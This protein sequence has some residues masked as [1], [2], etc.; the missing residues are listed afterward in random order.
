MAITAEQLNILITATNTASKQFAA[1]RRDANTMVR[2]L[3]ATGRT[4]SR[5]LTL[6]LLAIG[7]AATKMAV[8]FDEEMTKIITLVGVAEVQVDRWRES[9]LALGP[10][11]GVGPTELARALF[12]VTS[13]GERGAEA[14]KIVEFAAMAAAIGLGDTA[15]TARAVTAAMQAY[16]EE[17]L[18]AARATDILV[19]TVRAGNLVAADLAGSLGRVLATASS[20]SVSFQEVG[21]FIATFT[22]LGVSAEE[23]TTALR[24]VLSTII[25]PVGDAKAALASV[26]LTTEDLIST[27]REDGLLAVLELLIDRFD[28]DVVAIR[29]VIPNV[30]ALTGVLATAGQ[31]GEAYA[32][33]LNDLNTQLNVT[34]TAFNRAK[35]TP[36]QEWKVF[37]AEIQAVFI[38][39]GT[40]LIPTF[41]NLI[42][43]I[44]DMID[45]WTKLSDP[46]QNAIIKL[47]GFA[48]IVGPLILSVGLLGK[49]YLALTG[50]I[51][52]ATAALVAFHAQQIAVQLTFIASI[53]GLAA[54]AVG[55]I[56]IGKAALDAEKAQEKLFE[57]QQ[58]TMTAGAA[59]GDL[60]N[61]KIMALKETNTELFKSFVA[62]RR[63]LV[64]QGVGAIRA[65]SKAWTELG[66]QAVLAA[67]EAAKAGKDMV[68]P[69]TEAEKAALAFS[70]T[71]QEMGAEMKASFDVARQMEAI[72]G[73]SFD[74]TAENV[75]IARAAVRSFIEAGADLDTVVTQNG[76]TIR[77]L[78]NFVMGYD[79]SLID[80]AASSAVLEKSMNA[81]KA[82]AAKAKNEF[83]DLAAAQEGLAEQI[84]SI[85]ETPAEEFTRQFTIAQTLLD[86]GRI[87]PAE[88]ARYAAV[89]QQQLTDAMK[90]VEVAAAISG[91]D[92][93]R[94]LV[95]GMIQGMRSGDLG[96]ALENAAWRLVETGII[97]IITGGLGIA[98]PSQLAVEWGRSVVEGFT[99]GL[100]GMN[101]LGM[102]FTLGGASVGVGGVGG[103]SPAP[104]SAGPSAPAASTGQSVVIHQQINAGFGTEGERL[105]AG[106]AARQAGRDALTGVI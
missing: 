75:D 92:I 45:G 28:G 89:I 17:A 11:V 63:D 93:T 97:A 99:I 71:I 27:L 80:A 31:Q 58:R 96:A 67:A 14:L 66:I 20:L 39:L 8:T 7:A 53:A 74:L 72:Y 44:G 4:L 101:N 65:A 81:I 104:V 78:A 15:T 98:S 3:R 59:L 86:E 77:E 103:G 49:A 106:R 57:T 68:P 88:F 87:D 55:L 70:K 79:Q 43:A 52:K 42:N 61:A 26:N 60:W 84:R 10:A 40:K 13:A 91:E 90:P 83:R 1:V 64:S 32:G 29:R 30:R 48:L 5:T 21:A 94:A 36:A 46:I 18:S 85:I 105:N 19:G 69:L 33:I 95:S 82:A 22:R 6:P 73:D 12:V 51:V 37:K 50:A 62:L 76:I 34:A 23:A 24:Q 47:A 25:G 56:A 16:K 9:I 38:E 54:I 35:R 2:S 100:S 102:N 41:L